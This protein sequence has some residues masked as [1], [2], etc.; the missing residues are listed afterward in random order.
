MFLKNKVQ[1]QFKSNKSYATVPTYFLN[2]FQ[3]SRLTIVVKLR[4]FD[5]FVSE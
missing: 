1:L 3:F 4:R 5:N 2:A